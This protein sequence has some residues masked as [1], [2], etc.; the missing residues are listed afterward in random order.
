MIQGRVA[1]REALRRAM[2]GCDAAFHCAEYDQPLDD[3]LAGGLRGALGSAW[4]RL[5]RK[6]ESAFAL[7]QRNLECVEAVLSV[8]LE[9]GINRMICLNAATVPTA[10]ERAALCYHR[11]RGL[12]VTVLRP[13]TLYGPFCPWTIDAVRA[14]R[15]G[16]RPR[17][18]PGP[19]VYVDHLVEAM[20]LA[21][22]TAAGAGE[23]FPL[24]DPEPASCEKLLEAHAR[25]LNCR[26]EPASAAGGREVG[27]DADIERARRVLGYNPT[28]GFAQN[29]ERTAAWIKWSRL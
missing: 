26:W 21:A 8:A 13:A 2:V 7:P 28:S 11:E 29:I 15:R 14:L 6:I 22:S 5:A 9:S 23:V 3:A 12:S 24:H 27:G 17:G 1:D 4:C 25:A 18:G 10:A 20:L 16:R 19:C